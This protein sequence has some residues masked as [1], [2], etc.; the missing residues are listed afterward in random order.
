MKNLLLLDIKRIISSKE[1]YIAIIIIISGGIF[2]FIRNYEMYDL[3]LLDSVGT[4]NIFIYSNIIS[5]FVLSFLSPMVAVLP[6]CLASFDDLKS[7]FINHIIISSNRFKYIKTRCISTALSSAAVFLI[8]Y[9]VMMMGIYII[10]QTASVRTDYRFGQYLNVYDRSLL[11][12]C[13]AFILHSMVFGMV[14]S[15]LGLGVAFN[16]KNKF[17]VLAFPLLFY[18]LPYYFAQIFPPDIIKKLNAFL[19]FLTFEITTLDIELYKNY[20]QMIFTLL[21]SIILIYVGYKKRIVAS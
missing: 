1:F 6:F 7:G 8:A 5:N 13:L 3:Y 20:L 12:Y 14:F 21:I 19:P 16:A 4:L 17:M 2:T 18:Y 15:L 11:L 10:D 9:S